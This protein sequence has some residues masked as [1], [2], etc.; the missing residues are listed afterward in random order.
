MTAVRAG[1]WLLTPEVDLAPNLDRQLQEK[2]I[3]S[4]TSAVWASVPRITSNLGS[5]GPVALWGAVPHPK[6]FDLCL[7][8]LKSCQMFKLELELAPW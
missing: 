7:V 8:P 5:C 4:W 2:L 1:A 3:Q 6:A